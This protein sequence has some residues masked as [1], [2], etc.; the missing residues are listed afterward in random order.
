MENTTFTIAKQSRRQRGKDSHSDTVQR[1]KS[2]RR[3]QVHPI[4]NLQS[5]IGNQRVMRF[6]E[7]NSEKLELGLPTMA[8]VPDRAL[9]DFNRIPSYPKPRARAYPA[10]GDA[11]FSRECYRPKITSKQPFMARELPPS[12]HL[13]HGLSIAA[14]GA[15]PFIKRRASAPRIAIQMALDCSSPAPKTLDE[16]KNG[17]ALGLTKASASA[18]TYGAEFYASM[19]LPYLPCAVELKD[20]PELRL[21]HFVYT[22]AGEYDD[23]LTE[24]SG[25]QAPKKLKITGPMSEKIKEAEIEHCKDITFAWEQ[26]WARFIP[27]LKAL[28]FEGPGW[29]VIGDDRHKFCRTAGRALV[30]K[31]LGIAFDDLRK[32]AICLINKSQDRDNKPNELHTPDLGPP[33]KAAGCE[34]VTFTPDPESLVHV[35]THPSEEVV[36]GCGEPPPPSPTGEGSPLE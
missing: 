20:E 11:A 23:G 31:Q 35:G 3:S 8:S 16:A 29:N 15:K 13:D 26:T 19:R 7:V 22:A 33:E 18:S 17:G 10:V 27:Y 2:M 9:H 1:K 12:V 36:K 21:E 30:K 32:V 6:L 28:F 24:C 4:L 14:T 34:Q 5:I 25:R